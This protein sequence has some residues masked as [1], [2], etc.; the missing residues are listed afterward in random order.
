MRVTPS[1]LSAVC[2][3]ESLPGFC[4][5]SKDFIVPRFSYQCP[6]RYLND[7]VIAVFPGTQRTAAVSRVSCLKPSVILEVSECN[8]SSDSF[9]DNVPAFS[10]VTAVWA[11]FGYEFLAPET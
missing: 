4:E 6:T 5:V 1:A 3:D 11:A 2:S 7:E 8:D 9:D 10:A